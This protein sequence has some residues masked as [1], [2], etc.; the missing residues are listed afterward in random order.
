MH[1][2]CLRGGACRAFLMRAKSYGS[3]KRGDLL[4]RPVDSEAGAGMTSG[5]G[6]PS[7]LR[8]PSEAPAYAAFLAHRVVRAM[9]MTGRGLLAGALSRLS[10]LSRG[11][12]CGEATREIRPQWNRSSLNEALFFPIPSWEGLRG[13]ELFPRRPARRGSGALLVFEAVPRAGP[14]HLSLV[15][16]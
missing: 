8:A 5:S 6:S 16:L 13:E 15:G 4:L 7:R 11:C 3:A 1:H 12:W 10:P 14:E 9:Q 2:A